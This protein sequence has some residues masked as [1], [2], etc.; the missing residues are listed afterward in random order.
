MT[1]KEYLES[2]LE[3]EKLSDEEIQEIREKRDEVEELIRK[4]YGSKIVSFKYSGSIAKKTAIKSSKDLDLAVHFKKDS[5][6]TLKEMFNSVKEFLEKH[7]DG[8]REQRVS[9]GIP[10]LNVDVV[11]GRRID[12]EDLTNNDVYLYRSDNDS[13]IKTNIEVHKTHITQSGCRDVIKLTKIWR[14]NWGLK[15]KSFAIELLVIQALKS[16]EST[17]LKDKFKEVLE[18][19]EEN[20][21]SVNLVD[22]ANQNNNVADIIDNSRK[23][24]MKLRASNC[25][26]ILNEAGE[27]MDEQVSAWKQVFNDQNNIFNSVLSFGVIK[28]ETSDWGHQPNRRHGNF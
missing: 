19:I 13:W 5:F 3:Q 21:E 17:T 11:P 14:N 28:R 2:L 18:Y 24:L 23:T 7:Y 1:V 27:S 26:R 16:S 25:L 22:P 20:I 9:I 4:E 6:K 12:E 15:F 10:S 8:I